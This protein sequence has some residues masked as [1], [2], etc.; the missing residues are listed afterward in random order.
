MNGPVDFERALAEC[1]LIAIL[2]GIRPTEVI[3]IGETLID[4]GFRLIEV[5]LNS[6]DP[7]ASI[8]LLATRLGKRAVVGAG[9]VLTPDEVQSVY[10][11]GGRMTVSPNANPTVI[12]ATVK[13]GMA[14]VP[15]YATPSEAFAAIEAGAHALKLFPAEGASPSALR[16]QR[17]VFPKELPVVVVGGVTVETMAPWLEAGAAG[18]GLG[19]ALY[20]P[21]AIAADVS[22]L[23]HRFISAWKTQ[24]LNR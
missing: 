5:P 15:G 19:S 6:P 21:G 17:A 4:A 2:R 22:A 9:T 10:A 23:A 12:A 13:S 20:R 14:C 24:R 18:F 7:L 8:E 11:A 3:A 16:A 1:P